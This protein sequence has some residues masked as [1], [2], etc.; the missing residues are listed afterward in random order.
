M[1]VRG[2]NVEECVRGDS[3]FLP[4]LRF[5]A[6]QL[7]DNLVGLFIQQFCINFVLYQ[8]DTNVPMFNLP[9]QSI[10]QEEGVFL[11]EHFH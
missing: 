6:Q 7:V 2:S 11:A 4:Q 5:P 1:I 9:R 3:F 10:H 8:L